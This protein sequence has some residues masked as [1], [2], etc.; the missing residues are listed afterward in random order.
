MQVGEIMTSNPELLLT[1]AIIT[2][3]A[4]KLRE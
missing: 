1:T 4:K 2:E 3:A